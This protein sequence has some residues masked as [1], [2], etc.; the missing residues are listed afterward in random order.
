MVHVATFVP[1]VVKKSSKK[2]YEIYGIFIFK[3]EEHHMQSSC[4]SVHPSI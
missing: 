2:K 3:N 4:L 1:Y